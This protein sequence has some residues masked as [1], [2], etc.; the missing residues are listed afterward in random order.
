MSGRGSLTIWLS[1]RVS[2]STLRPVFIA[3][4]LMAPLAAGGAARPAE[5]ARPPAVHLAEPENLSAS[6]R[7]EVRGRMA[8][9]GN[10]MS[11]L[12]TAVVLLDRP[13][14]VTLA[15]RIADE[16]VV[17]RSE[18]ATTKGWEARLPR[19]FFIEQDALRGAARELAAAATHGDA[20]NVTADRFAAVA[21]TCV[22]CHSLYLHGRADSAP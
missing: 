1:R 13:T 6:T 20:D 9:H 17:A 16:E 2:L 10:T 8:R 12:V 19:G 7:A 3:G 14:I 11:N 21:R 15:L 22:A 18:A 4:L 5:H